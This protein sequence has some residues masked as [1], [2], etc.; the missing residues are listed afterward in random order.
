M[1]DL[2]DFDMLT[3]CTVGAWSPEDLDAILADREV[4]FGPL[5]RT[6]PDGR[7]QYYAYVRKVEDA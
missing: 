2:P 4:L 6:L 1:P 7:V 3:T 5:Q